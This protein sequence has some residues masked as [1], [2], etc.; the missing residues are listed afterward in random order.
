MNKLGLLVVGAVLGLTRCDSPTIYTELSKDEISENINLAARARAA[1]YLDTLRAELNSFELNSL[2]DNQPCDAIVT[3]PSS[4][5]DYKLRQIEP[6]DSFDYT[7][8]I[9]DPGDDWC[10]AQSSIDSEQELEL[11]LP[12]IGLDLDN[13]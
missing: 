5:V 8:K 2:M 13:Q 3:E 10:I 12:D 11:V 1:T 9:V 6:D 4:A 7:L